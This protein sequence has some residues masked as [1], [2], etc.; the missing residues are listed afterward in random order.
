MKMKSCFGIVILL[1]AI[2]SFAGAATSRLKPNYFSSIWLTYDKCWPVMVQNTSYHPI[3]IGWPMRD[4]LLKMN[5]VGSFF[6]TYRASLAK[7]V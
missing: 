2:V 5:M 6:S 3:S 1:R 7:K 4:C